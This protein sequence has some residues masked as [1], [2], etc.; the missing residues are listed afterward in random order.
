MRLLD[1]A[2]APFRL[3]RRTLQAQLAV[4]YAAVFG[5]SCVAVGAV[6]VIFKPNFLVRTSCAAGPGIPSNPD[7][8]AQNAGLSFAGTIFH[9]ASQNVAGVA[10]AAFVAVLALGVGW[11]IAGRVLR[12][13]RTMTSAARDISATNLSRRLAVD[14]PND[15]FRQ[16]G[17]T[18][19]S[20]FGRLEA[21][22]QTQRHFVAN[23]SHELRTPLTAEKAVLQVALADPQ[24]STATLRSACEKALQWNDQQDRLIDSLLTLASSEREIERWE[25]LDLADGAGKAIL[26]CQE[27]AERRGIRIDATLASAP[28]TGDPALAE[29]LI[30]NLV[31]NAIQ[32]NMDG[33]LVEITTGITDGLAVITVSNTGPLVP[34]DE[35][36]RLF[37]PFQRLGTQRLRQP[38][39]HGL[40]LAIVS[41]VVSVHGATLT[42][43]ARPAG[44]LD[45]SISFP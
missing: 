41:A 12:P 9:D 28:V 34:A 21:S 6:A 4:L 44:G 13:L 40:G 29:S 25:P 3:P 23:A 39:G 36:D 38:S 7:S 15:E 30:A 10:M 26:S 27:E 42:A 1:T 45:I 35:V 20:L 43:S 11:L 5:L 32:H 22:F 24:A 19:D 33:G 17:D 2:T 16:L 37:Q 8:C 18:L 14:G 31:G